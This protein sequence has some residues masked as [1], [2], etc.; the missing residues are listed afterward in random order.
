MTRTAADNLADLAGNLPA[1]L[2]DASTGTDTEKAIVASLQ[3]AG[4]MASPPP[5]PP[6]SLLWDQEPIGTAASG[7]VFAPVTVQIL[8]EFGA[9][10]SGDDTTEVTVAL[11]SSDPS[12]PSGAVLS[13]T[14]TRTVVAGVATF[15]DLSVNLPYDYYG[16][17][18]TSSA[19]DGGLAPAYSYNF[20]VGNVLYFS[21]NP[22]E[23]PVNGV[24]ALIEVDIYDYTGQQ[25][26][27]DTTEVTVALVDP[28]DATLSGTVTRTLAAGTAIFDDLS[29]DTAGAYTLTASGADCYCYPSFQFEIVK[30]G[31]ALAFGVQPAATFTDEG[32]ALIAPAMTVEVHDALDAVDTTD[33]TT[34]VTIEVAFGYGDYASLTGGTL[35]RTVVAGVAT[36]DDV[37]VDGADPAFKLRATAID[38]DP[39]DSDEFWV[40]AVQPPALE[41]GQQPSN[42]ASQCWEVQ[43]VYGGGEIGGGTFDILTIPYGHA[44]SGIPWNATHQEV[45]A[46]VQGQWPDAFY[47]VA[48]TGGPIG[49]EPFV[50]DFTGVPWADLAEITVDG[51]NL[52]G[53]DPTLGVRTYRDGNSAWMSPSVTVRVL[54]ENGDLDESDSATKVFLS[55]ADGR[56]NTDLLIGSDGI[57]NVY[58]TAIAVAGVATFEFMAFGP[59]GQ[60]VLSLLA[61]GAVSPVESDA[62]TVAAR[63]PRIPQD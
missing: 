17:V 43:Q 53:V 33:D 28:G 7:E 5:P 1:S 29:V 19:L 59:V 4:L 11:D 22:T 21:V 57:S 13:G 12:M 3:G 14:L 38:L 34:E 20:G 26:D 18:A 6:A 8:D 23:T 45:E 58:L 51:S 25:M 2:V 48:V 41:F 42:V 40:G 16:L 15:D 35:T 49:S 52:T 44:V 62:F 47:D 63:L 31:V 46:L 60:T 61:S 37:V 9:V 54:D 27:D 56:L 39:A 36:F 30:L 55:N 32:P 24:I 50:F 10:I